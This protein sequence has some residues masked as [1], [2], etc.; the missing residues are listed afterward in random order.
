MCLGHLRCQLHPRSPLSH[1]P[2]P[3]PPSLT[4]TRETRIQGWLLQR[5]E[6]RMRLELPEGQVRERLYVNDQARRRLALSSPQL[7]PGR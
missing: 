2:I 1:T 6:V 5:K 3:S 4:V 7:T